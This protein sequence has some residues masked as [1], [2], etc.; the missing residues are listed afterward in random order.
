MPRETK[1]A[2]AAVDSMLAPFQENNN[3]DCPKAFL[4]FNDVEDGYRVEWQSKRVERIRDG[5]ELLPEYDDRFRVP[6][7]FGVGSDT[8]AAP[9]TLERVQVPLREMYPDFDQFMK[10]YAGYELDPKMGRYGYW[11]NPNAKWDW[12]SIGGRYT[13]R[14]GGYDPQKDSKNYET[15]F[16][17]NGTGTRPGTNYDAEA[18]WARK[19]NELFP[20]IGEGCNAC[21]GAGVSLKFP[22]HFR[23]VGNVAPVSELP[24]NFSCF[25]MLT[26]EGE[27]IERGTMGWWG[28]VTDE[29]DETAWKRTIRTVLDRY[30]SCIAVGVDCHI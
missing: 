13:G 12:F 7:T 6:G 15:C 23:D 27:W 24:D 25:A 16:I 20:C 2:K 14:M 29:K 3:G 10:E 28:I 8:H 26:P 4:K 22:S 30:R 21:Y 17:C 9:A 1:D 11:E 18:A 19:G 5:A